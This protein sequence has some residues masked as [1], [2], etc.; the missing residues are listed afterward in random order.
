MKKKREFSIPLPWLLGGGLFAIALLIPLFLETYW[1][2]VI[3]IAYFYAL[4][5]SSWSLLAGYAG[6]FYFGH[7][8]FMAIVGRSE[9]KTACQQD[10]LAD[11][12]TLGRWSELCW[13]R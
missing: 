11:T 5:A 13:E 8:A 3:I 7:M 6:Q 12:L 9:I 4:L 10:C 2:H 1:L